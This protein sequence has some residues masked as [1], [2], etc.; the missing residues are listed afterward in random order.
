[1]QKKQKQQE[2]SEISR[3]KF[4]NSSWTLFFFLEFQKTVGDKIMQFKC[5]CSSIESCEFC[6]RQT[7]AKNTRKKIIW[8]FRAFSTFIR[9]TN[10]F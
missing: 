8:H 3:I 1:M 9:D 10:V 2:K 4:S 5:V 6:W 7:L